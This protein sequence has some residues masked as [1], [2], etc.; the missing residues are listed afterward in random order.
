LALSAARR[1]LQHAAL[2]NLYEL[3]AVRV[4]P[5]TLAT[6]LTPLGYHLAHLPMDAR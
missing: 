4:A 2:R 5:D 3:Q 1:P 6:S